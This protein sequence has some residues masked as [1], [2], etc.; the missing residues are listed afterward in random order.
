MKKMITLL[1]AL[2][3]SVMLTAQD[4]QIIDP[5]TSHLRQEIAE[6]SDNELIRINIRLKAQFD[7]TEFMARRNNSTREQIREQLVGELKL[8]THAHQKDILSELNYYSRSNEVS[9]IKALW[10]ANIINCYATPEVIEQLATRTDIERIDIDEERILLYP[11]S[12]SEDEGGST[13]E[14]TY[15]VNKLNAPAVWGLGFTGEGIVV[16]VLDTG[17]N[18]NHNDLQ[19]NMWTHP[20]YPFHGWSFVNSNNNPMDFHGHGTHCAGT[21]AGNGASGSQTGVAPGAKIMALQVLNSGGGGTE[22]GVWDAIQFGVEEGAN[23][24]SLSLGW[25]HAWGPDRPAWRTVMDNALAAGVVASVAA[26]NEGDQQGSYP[27]PDNVRTPGD[28]PPPWLHPD[29]TLIGGISAVITIGATNSNDALAG[30]SG[31][32]PVTW[33]NISQFADY[34]YNPGIGLIR[35]D[36][37]APGVSVKSLSHSNTSGYTNMSG[38]SMAT[39]GAAGVMALLLSK[40]PGLLPEQMSQIL[41]ETALVLSPGKNNNSGSG[42][43][44]AL[45]AFNA[46]SFPGPVYSSHVI[47]DETGNNDGII[48]PSEDIQLSISLL[49][50]TDEV[51]EDIEAYIFTNSPYINMVDSVMMYGTFQPGDTIT[52]EN[53]FSFAV[54]DN[55]PGGHEIQFLIQT[56]NEIESWESSFKVNAQAPVLGS[57]SMVVFDPEGNGN[58]ILDPGEQANIQILTLNSGQLEASEVTVTFTTQSSFVTVQTTQLDLGTIAAGGSSMAVFP[59]NVSEGAPLGENILFNYTIVSGFYTYERTYTHKIGMML[60]DFE[61]GDFSKYNW[62]FSGNLPYTT[63][64]VNPYEGQY[65]A[66]SGAI[67]NNQT[68]VMQL[69]MN[70]AQNDSVTFY[71]KVSSED[72]YDFFRFYIGSEQKGQWSGEVP[73]QRVAY[74]VTPG[75]KTFRWEYAKDASVVGG[76]DCAWVDY[77]SLPQPLVTTAYAGPDLLICE[78]ETVQLQGN[79]MNY[80]SI[81]WFTSGSGTFSNPNILDPVYTPSQQD[82]EAG[83]V[84]LM[85]TVSNPSNDQISDQLSLTIQ[86]AVHVFAGGDQI[87]CANTNFLTESAEAANHSG[88]F[89]ASSGSGFFADAAALHTSYTPSTDDLTAGSVILTLHG[90]GLSPCGDEESSFTLTFAQPIMLEVDDIVH[91]CDGGATVMNAMIS[92][93]SQVLWTSEGTGSFDDPNAIN[94]VYTPSA[95]DIAAGS[96]ELMIEVS[97]IGTCENVIET[98]NLVFVASPTAEIT[99]NT[100]ICEGQSATI[101]FVLSGQAPWTV[102]AADMDDL[103]ITESPFQLT[104][105][106]YSSVVYDFI[107]IVDAN[108]CE[109]TDAGQ[110][111][112]TV[113]PLPLVPAKPAGADTVDYAYNT[114]SVFTTEAA[115]FATDYVWEFSPSQA[116]T[117]SASVTEFTVNW[118]SEFIGEVTIKVQSVNDCG[119]SEFSE[120]KTIYLKN[121]IGIGN[122]DFAGNVRIFP[123]PSE[124]LFTL[125]LK[126][127]KSQV[128][129]IKV[130]NLLGRMV[131]SH[132]YPLLSGTASL[133]LDLRNLPEGLYML[134]IEHEDGIMSSK[135]IIN[136]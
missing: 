72:N 122:L 115:N 119:T 133:A 95:D 59:I 57:G 105:V 128:L 91:S 84:V 127:A 2:L 129:T 74:A 68:T 36:V 58:G 46:T 33:Q 28:C 52:I 106:P 7:A 60:E 94:P 43:I 117:V 47:N 130:H 113:N 135:L 32:G 126:S 108:G 66:K 55:I 90:D 45:A 71:F 48:N 38:T 111:T 63:T 34:P 114:S 16:A 12:K 116:G 14:I 118:S 13:R 78:S 83:E 65:S 39:P 64:D 136:R 107:S 53:G 96:I 15:N 103:I 11:F 4:F 79:A 54:A 75:S 92:N 18:Y 101:D 17:V 29:Q 99:G 82:V 87:A 25:L 85:L 37:V 80:T 6:V 123:N 51:F 61:T 110:V 120:V 89:W 104:F 76:S 30:F 112:V 124:G 50:N 125:E 81:N 77:I 1:M 88:L 73:W 24:L 9:D 67:G 31:R 40:N 97:G 41:E 56:S 62:T 49:N 8:F 26:G 19:G 22:S 10:I 69:S 27:I 44:D 100:T 109:I 121:T 131:E 23:V 35:P 3:I 5:V 20:D 21:V 86:Q 70:V 134:Q 132:V 102:I 98:I 42:R 93:H